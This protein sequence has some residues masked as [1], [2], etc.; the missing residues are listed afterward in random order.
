MGQEEANPVLG[1][2]IASGHRLQGTILLSEV[3]PRTKAGIAWDFE[4][5]APRTEEDC[6]GI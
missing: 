6:L 5:P 1:Q 3:A 2:E 4:K